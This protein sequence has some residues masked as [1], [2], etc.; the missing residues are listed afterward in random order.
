M[1]AVAHVATAAPEKSSPPLGVQ[2]L[3]AKKI[4]AL[5]KE[6]NAPN[7]PG[8]SVAVIDKGKIVFAKG[9][10]IANLEY[11]VPI[12]TETIFHV[13]SVSK[14]FTAMAVVL[15]ESEGKLSL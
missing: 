13:A 15:L 8:V 3:P 2:D 11:N 12:K 9:Y 7:T 6:W 14:Q 5:F 4:D 1:L 10:G